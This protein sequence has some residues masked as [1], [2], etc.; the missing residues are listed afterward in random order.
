M[1][2]KKLKT[3]TRLDC[4]EGALGTEI[5]SLISASSL[6]A[7]LLCLDSNDFKSNFDSLGKTAFKNV[8]VLVFILSKL[9]AALGLSAKSLL[10]TKLVVDLLGCLEVKLVKFSK[11]SKFLPTSSSFASLILNLLFKSSIFAGFTKKELL[12][13]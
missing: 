1:N 2:L 7:L 10:N 4:T 3:L 6:R 13:S 5:L 12:M 11:F 8:S 9:R